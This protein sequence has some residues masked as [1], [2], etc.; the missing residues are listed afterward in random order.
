MPRSR[1]WPTPEQE[2][3]LRLALCPPARFGDV[4]PAAV[5]RAF[6]LVD[7]DSGSA[8]PAPLLGANLERHG[9][10]DPGLE[11]LRGAYERTAAANRA[12]FEHVAQVIHALRRAG[13]PTVV[14][15]GPALVARYYL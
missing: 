15:K 6:D 3:L 14:L 9:A 1:I 12:L 4:W 13:I 2:L 11:K 8:R 10:R 7:L 5:R